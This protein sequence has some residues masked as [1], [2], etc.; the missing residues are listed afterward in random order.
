MP[1]VN[2]RSASKNMSKAKR[3]SVAKNARRVAAALADELELCTY[4]KV[5][6]ACGNKM[7]I[8]S[9]PEKKE[10]LA[11]IRGKMARVATNDVVLLNIREYESRSESDSA[12]FDIVAVFSP[13]DISKL[14]KNKIIP[15]WMVSSSDETDAI[16]EELFEYG[17]ADDDDDED[18]GTVDKRDKKSHRSSAKVEA[19][20]DVDI[21]DV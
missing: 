14:V 12:V 8:I 2:A 19:D 18:D 13:K 17:G 10:H 16:M 4:G 15:S 21:D 7:F 11:H 6:R 20:S 1:V 3:A 5:V 9:T